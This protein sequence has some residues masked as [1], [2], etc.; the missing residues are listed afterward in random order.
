MF[1]VFF[2]LSFSFI[3]SDGV[4][5]LNI[6]ANV[7]IGSWLLLAVLEIFV[8]DDDVGRDLQAASLLH[9]FPFGG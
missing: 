3:P 7:N 8:Q 6:L 4:S 9:Q 5:C 1:T 2:L